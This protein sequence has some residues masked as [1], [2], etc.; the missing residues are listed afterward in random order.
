MAVAEQVPE[1]LKY[2]TFALKVSI[3]CEG[4]KREVKKSLQHIEGVY[5]ICID[6]QQHKVVVTGNVKAETLVKKLTKTGKHAELWPEHMP[7]VNN[8]E[9]KG[10]K[11]NKTNDGNTS[12]PPQNPERK[13]K[14]SFVNANSADEKPEQA[15]KS[16][17]GGKKKVKKDHINGVEVAPS[18]EVG[19]GN[20]A[21]V[22][23]QP[24]NLPSYVLSYSSVQ[25]SMSSEGEYYQMLVPESWYLYSPLAGS[26]EFFNE[27]NASDCSIM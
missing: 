8:A 16:G 10:K 13:Q 21:I 2:Q 20:E 12:Q 7:T 14:N 17:G 26:C 22:I 1:P 4:C 5:K 6:P 11:N 15:A 3:H 23:P 25:P 19:G 27:E 9:K 24:L 18:K